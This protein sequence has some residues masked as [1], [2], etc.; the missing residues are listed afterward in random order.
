MKRILTTICTALPLI[1]GTIACDSSDGKSTLRISLTDAPADYE[2]VVVDVQDIEINLAEEN[3]NGWQSVGSFTPAQ[4]DLLELS[5]GVDT[6]LASEELPAGRV[7]QIRL[8]LGDNNFLINDGEKF[9]L[10]TPSAQQS[11]LKL[12][13]HADLVEGVAYEVKLDWDAAKSI[14]QQGNGSYSLKPV[15]R[16]LTD[17]T[18]GA[19]KG[20]VDTSEQVVAFAIQG[21]DTLFSSYT[22]DE[23]TFLLQG[24]PAGSYTVGFD[25]TDSLSIQDVTDV[26]VTTGEQQDLGVIEVQVVQ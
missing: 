22:N 26:V 11:G 19:I 1:F 16:V 7:S 8:I 9:E 5:A 15:I 10:S 2:S 13:I 20:Q 3:G 6:L 4:I 18:S 24:V 12:N 17:A 25:V 23:G 14:V 21:T